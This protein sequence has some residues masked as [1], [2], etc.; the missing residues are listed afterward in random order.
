MK[1]GSMRTGWF[2]CWLLLLLLFLGS[3]LVTMT[4]TEVIWEEGDSTGKM[5]PLD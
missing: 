3:F 2:C 4:Q 1:P 5:P